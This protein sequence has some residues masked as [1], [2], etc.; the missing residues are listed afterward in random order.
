M[1]ESTQWQ[2][3]DNRKGVFDDYTV[4]GFKYQNPDAEIGWHITTSRIEVSAK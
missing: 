2:T 3:K 1:Q 4:M